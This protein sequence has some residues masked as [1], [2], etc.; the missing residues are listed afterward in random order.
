MSQPVTPLSLRWANMWAAAYYWRKWAD[1]QDE[2]VMRALLT[3][4]GT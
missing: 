2:F 1:T 4:R 3:M